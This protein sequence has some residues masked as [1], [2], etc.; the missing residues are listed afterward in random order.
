MAVYN[1]VEGW[2][3]QQFWGSGEFA[4]PFGNFEV[5]ITVPADH[6]LEA[7]GVLQNRNEVFTPEQ[8]S[9][10]AQAEKSFDKPV[11]VVTQQEAMAAE[12]GFSDKKKTWKFKAENVRDFGIA[13]SRKF[14][15]DAMA[16]KLGGKNVM[17]VSVYPK[18]GNPLWGE[19]STRIV[20][21]T[22]K[23]YSS[24]TFDYPYPK[25]VSV[26]AQDQGMEYPMICWNWGRPEK[27]GTYSDRVKNGMMSVIVHEVGH[28]FSQ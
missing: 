12:K 9:R 1:D 2:Q 21:H 3:N 5:N 23:S 7:T 16:V 27:D 13:T 19:Y 22:L 8:L 24:H 18:E 6:V 28:N 4:L 11:V 17:A 15:Y 25:A 20:A 14:I 26:H 10:Y